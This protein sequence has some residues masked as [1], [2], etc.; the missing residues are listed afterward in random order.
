MRIKHPEWR[1]SHEPTKFPF[2]DLAT[3]QNT[4]GD[5]ILEGTFLDAALY[6]PGGQSNMYL[7]KVIVDAS[8][9]TLYI[10]DALTTERAS[11]EFNPAEAP[12]SLRLTD[13][14]GRAAGIL[15]SEAQRLA[16]FLSW[17]QGTHEFAIDETPFVAE[18]CVPTPSSGLQGVQ[19]PNGDI[20]HGDIWLV[21]DDGIVLSCYEDEIPGECGGPA[22]VES[23]IRV[24]VIGDPLFRRRL[25]A[26]PGEFPTQ[27]F[28]ESLTFCLP[29]TEGTD[30][31]AGS[32]NTSDT[33]I[34]LLMDTTGSMGG[35]I[36]TFK[37]IF[38][39]L[40]QEINALFPEVSFKWG[41]A[42][43]RDFGDYPT[44]WEVGQKFT[45]SHALAQAAIN[46]WT[47]GGGGDFTEAQLKAL[48]D[49]ANNW[50]TAAL[51]GR[52]LSAANRIVVWA[53]DY[54]GHEDA[55]EYPDLVQT[56]IALT[57]ANVTVIGLN[58]AGAGFGIDSRDVAPGTWSAA[59]QAAYN[60]AHHDGGVN[61]ASAIATATGGILRN[62]ITASDAEAVKQLVIDLLGS[63]IID[64]IDGVPGSPQICYTCGPGTFGDIKIT[65]GSSLAPDT[66][67]RIRSVSEGLVVEAAGEKLEGIR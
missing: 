24:D 25:C 6:P 42:D 47:A 28:L 49:I 26:D 7:S 46:A 63:V 51:G 44:A 60:A 30:G 13:S 33:D 17:G 1:P 65:V 22:I 14:Y 4:V 64:G 8:L 19:L 18:V 37:E 52:P 20:V 61:Q 56:I 50:E 40:A 11:V 29:P 57:A 41:V 48:T 62:N 66:V 3:L 31:S 67:L 27:R 21:G 10:G 55:P 39:P 38:E 54:P 35:F 58:T 9:V 15:V 59:Q 36:A 45:P 53:G 16:T 43:Y 32:T 2:E 23:V 12:E 5:V 34:L